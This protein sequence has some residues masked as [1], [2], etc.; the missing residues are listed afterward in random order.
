MGPLVMVS[1]VILK[2]WAKH[3]TQQNITVAEVNQQQRIHIVCREK[4]QKCVYAAEA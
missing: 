1:V 3:T 2:Y 4:K